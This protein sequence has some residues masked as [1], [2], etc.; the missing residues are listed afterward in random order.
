MIVEER[1][2]EG[3][4]FCISVHYLNCVFI[5]IKMLKNIKSLNSQK[6]TGS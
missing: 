5:K 2:K 4:C 3:K 6:V 1:Y